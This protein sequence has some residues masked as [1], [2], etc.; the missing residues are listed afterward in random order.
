MILPLTMTLTLTLMLF[1]QDP[2]PPAIVKPP[3]AAQAEIDA[4]AK[5]EN[6]ETASMRKAWKQRR[7]IIRVELESKRAIE[8]APAPVPVPHG[9][10]TGGTVVYIPVTVAVGMPAG[11]GGQPNMAIPPTVG[12][13]P[14]YW[15]CCYGRILRRFND[16]G[17]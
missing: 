8:E 3:R 1:G 4:R 11:M 13:L 7:H 5:K 2:L 14:P 9:L 17:L 12:Q 6:H 10:S 15:D 16:A